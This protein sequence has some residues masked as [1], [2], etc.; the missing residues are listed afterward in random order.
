MYFSC[1]IDGGGERRCEV[2]KRSGFPGNSGGC[3]CRLWDKHP[4]ID[5]SMWR[6]CFA[7]ECESQ[8]R[9]QA[10]GLLAKRVNYSL[11]VVGAAAV[12]CAECGGQILLDPARMRGQARGMLEEE[13]DLSRHAQIYGGRGMFVGWENC[14]RPD[15][16]VKVWVE[17]RRKRECEK[18]KEKW[19]PGRQRAM[20]APRRRCVECFWWAAS[21]F[22]ELPVDLLGGV[23]EC[24][25]FVRMPFFACTCRQPHAAAPRSPTSPIQQ[26]PC[27]PSKSTKREWCDDRLCVGPADVTQIQP[28]ELMDLYPGWDNALLRCGRMLAET[29]CPSVTACNR[30]EELIRQALGDEADYVL[31]LGDLVGFLEDYD[32]RRYGGGVTRAGCTSLG[33]LWK[34]SD[35]EFGHI[36]GS[37]AGYVLELLSERWADER[38]GSLLCHQGCSHCELCGEREDRRAVE[39]EEL[40]GRIGLFKVWASP[41]TVRLDVLWEEWRDV[42]LLEEQEERERMGVPATCGI[43]ALNMRG[44]GRGRGRK[45]RVGGDFGTERS[46]DLGTQADG[47][48]GH[49]Q[50]ECDGESE[51]GVIQQGGSCTGGQVGQRGATGPVGGDADGGDGFDHDGHDDPDGS[52]PSAQPSGGQSVASF[53]PPCCLPD[54][55]QLSTG[56]TVVTGLR[57]PSAQ[58]SGGQGLA[59]PRREET[60][61]FRQMLRLMPL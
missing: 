7:E 33:D 35:D 16:H 61:S 18:E 56:R 5:E 14:F 25:E 37:D 50:Q 23:C 34:K 59:T 15:G 6:S 13:Y 22:V 51:R 57:F 60:E 12:A 45:C 39:E 46:W 52:F 24:L 53:S 55:R 41:L 58:P 28:P 43:R 17:K 47:G 20:I 38:V 27:E 32:L 54:D 2:C 8:L 11:N 44:R 30:N 3:R 31:K 9:Q 26:T 21:N 10:A 49:A 42:I 1:Q 29:G 40:K 19:S 4:E 36:F 48:P